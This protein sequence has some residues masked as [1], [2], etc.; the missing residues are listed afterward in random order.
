MEGSL[1]FVHDSLF[2]Q[3]PGT[4][5]VCSLRV[6]QR[7]V[8][9]AR[10]TGNHDMLKRPKFVFLMETLVDSSKMEVICDLL[11][12]EACFVVDNVRHSGG[13]AMLWQE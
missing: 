2:T 13:L 11:R 10:P 1:V 6:D 7:W 5:E 4:D 9:V 12:Y 3:E 8:L